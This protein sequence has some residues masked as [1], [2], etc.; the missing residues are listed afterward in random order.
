MAKLLI[1]RFE[2][3]LTRENINSIYSWIYEKIEFLEFLLPKIKLYYLQVSN[4]VQITKEQNEDYLGVCKKCL[5][6]VNHVDEEYLKLL[7]YAPEMYEIVERYLKEN[8]DYDLSE[9]FRYVKGKDKV[10]EIVFPY[11]KDRL[12]EYGYILVKWS[13]KPF[14]MFKR[15]YNIIGYD[16]IFIKR[17]IFMFERKDYYQLFINLIPIVDMTEELKELMLDCLEGEEK[18]KFLE[19]I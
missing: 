12:K 3:E 13:S 16:F 7:Y 9:I 1:D 5:E 4:F 10:I 18:F 19:E 8:K 2:N 17:Y 6:Y 11:V 14:D 15:I